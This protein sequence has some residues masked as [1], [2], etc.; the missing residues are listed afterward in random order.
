MLKQ[1]WCPCEYRLEIYW[2]Q[3]ITTQASQTW[4]RQP[5]SQE[6]KSSCFNKILFSHREI[7]NSSSPNISKK[8]YSTPHFSPVG[9][10]VCGWIF[11]GFNVLGWIVSRVSM[12]K[13]SGLK[14]SRY[15]C[16][17][18]KCM[19]WIPQPIQRYSFIITWV[20][21]NFNNTRSFLSISQNN[22]HLCMFI[23]SIWSH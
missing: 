7:R 12:V 18:T 2:L 15:K 22:C 17:V 10:R 8:K 20:R 1:V 23:C 3:N 4:S 13:Q 21:F 14:S 9:C 11:H 6:L 5:W 16:T 19:K